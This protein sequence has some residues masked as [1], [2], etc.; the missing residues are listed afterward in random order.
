MNKIVSY[1]LV[2]IIVAIVSAGATVLVFNYIEPA[3]VGQTEV[4]DL[5]NIDSDDVIE[6]DFSNI[7]DL[8]NIVKSVAPFYYYR[9]EMTDDT[10]TGFNYYN[11]KYT[12]YHLNPVLNEDDI[13]ITEVVGPYRV[14]DQSAQQGM[15]PMIKDQ[16]ELVILDLLSQNLISV[17]TVNQDRRILDIKFSADM[18]NLYFITAD[19]P[20]TSESA[21]GGKLEMIDRLTE[22]HL[23]LAI[24][25]GIGLYAGFAI[26][27]VD[28][29]N[30]KV[31]V[32]SQGG[33]GPVSWQTS[34]VVDLINQ[35]F[36]EYGS[37]SRSY[38][39]GNNEVEG[40][41]FGVVNPGI[42]KTVYIT[43][44]T[45]IDPDDIDNESR[46]TPGCI[47]YGSFAKYKN[48]YGQAIIMSDISSKEK[49]EI[50]RNLDGENSCLKQTRVVHSL[51]WLDDNTI[52]FTTPDGIFSIEVNSQE[53][54][55]LFE[56]RSFISPNLIRSKDISFVNGDLFGLKTS[57]EPAV[58]DTSTGK[59]FAIPLRIGENKFENFIKF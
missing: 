13:K 59:E 8:D 45:R 43:T 30:N 36:D 33:D 23:S 14:L 25:D 18:N 58:Y 16:T 20:P 7:D 22:E 46:A 44:P 38:A 5:T 26:K 6:N 34:F 1:I 12:F 17:T 50:Y 10:G 24:G 54:N 47:K 39:Y 35:T 29:K 40:E 15:I 31:Y 56:F 42:T 53:V 2:A 3:E 11:R 41:I 48:D 28:N 21:Q 55:Q 51:Y 52:L 27:A 37:G 57:I 9:S 49:T 4:S 32:V 19:N